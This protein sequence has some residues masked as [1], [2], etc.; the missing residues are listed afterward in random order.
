ML[1]ELIFREERVHNLK[2]LTLLGF[3]TAALG[4]FAAGI[5][6]PSESGLV[7]VF[8]SAVA[9]VYP[10]TKYFLEHEKKDQPHRDEVK[11]YGALFLGQ[12][13]GFFAVGYLAPDM[14]SFQISMFESQLFTMG[15]T[16]YAVAGASFIRVLLNN[17]MVFTFILGTATVIGSAGVFILTWN[18]SVLG[19]FLAVLT[20]E[21]SHNYVK[22][23]TGSELIP[24]PI[25]YIPHASFEMAGFVT[26]GV[27]GSLMS[28]ALYR[29]HF[30]YE[31]W[32][33][34]GKLVAGGIILIF[35]GAFIETA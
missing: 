10:L 29:E 24:S 26:A 18:A 14:V 7:A 9:M 27:A 28:A 5:L 13:A 34:F 6:F 16:G 12:V 23:L 15:V 22:I 19:V 25:A 1:P 20:R 32:K 17:L 21:L 3:V 8:L 11:T 31:T 2:L 33:D 30:D 4:F 35:I